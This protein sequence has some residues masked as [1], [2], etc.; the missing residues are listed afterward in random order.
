MITIQTLIERTGSQIEKKFCVN[1]WLMHV[2][3]NPENRYVNI[4]DSLEMCELMNSKSFSEKH[5][6]MLFLIKHNHKCVLDYSIP[7]GLDLWSNFL[8]AAEDFA[9]Y[10]RSKC[11]YG[12]DPLVME[13]K[14]EGEGD[15]NLSIYYELDISKKYLDVKLPSKEFMISLSST[16]RHFFVKMIHEYNVDIGDEGL[17]IRAEKLIKEFSK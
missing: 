9:I 13:I 11:A 3:S 6:R 7:S 17:I 4:D 10:G 1:D 5:L 12:V 2:N 16:L 8:K 15:L 14:D